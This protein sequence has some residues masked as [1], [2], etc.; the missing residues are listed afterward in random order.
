M[1]G[2]FSPGHWLIV[3][4]V[5]LIVFGPKKLPEIGKSIGRALREF[6]KVRDD[7]MES[8]DSAGERGSRPEAR[9]STSQAAALPAAETP[10]LSAGEEGD[11][12]PYG[13]DFQVTPGPAT[14]GRGSHP[15]GPAGKAEHP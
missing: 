4:L 5:A 12:L 15:A 7:F 8:V 1:G 9:S 6:N 11:A 2:G 13:A 3:G 10:S 14:P